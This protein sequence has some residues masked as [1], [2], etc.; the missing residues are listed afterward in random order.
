L[1]PRRHE[2]ALDSQDNEGD[3]DSLFSFGEVARVN[4][5]RVEEEKSMKS[6]FFPKHDEEQKGII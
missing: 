5:F 1:M 4:R 3:K 2:P 6:A